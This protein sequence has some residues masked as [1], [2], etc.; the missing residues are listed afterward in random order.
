MFMSS[1]AL[2]SESGME[3]RILACRHEREI[4]YRKGLVFS[5]TVYGILKAN[6][7]HYP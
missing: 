1:T 4:C 3:D 6:I 2:A 5:P 7:Y